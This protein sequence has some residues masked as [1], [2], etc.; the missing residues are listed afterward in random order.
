MVATDDLI[1]HKKFIL[2][3]SRPYVAKMLELYP[4]GLL[5]FIDVRNT[6]HIA[7]IKHLG[8]VIDGLTDSYGAGKLPFF[9]FSKNLKGQP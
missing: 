2:K 1:K 5:N 4:D 9:R 8:F 7:Y 3:N 6:V